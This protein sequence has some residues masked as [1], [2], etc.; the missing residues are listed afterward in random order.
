MN[1]EKGGGLG[2]GS[3]SKGLNKAKEAKGKVDEAKG[4]V[5]EAKGK[6]DEAKGDGKGK[7]GEGKEGDE[8]G[9]EGDGKGKEG[10][11]KGKEGEGKGK[12]G[13]G[14]EGEG[15]G[16]EGDNCDANNTR[17]I[18]ED[19][20]N[21][22]I[23]LKEQI[24]HPMDFAQN[25][26][27]EKSKSIGRTVKS[28]FVNPLECGKTVVQSLTDIIPNGIDKASLALDRLSKSMSKFSGSMEDFF[29]GLGGLEVPGYPHVLGPFEV[30]YAKVMVDLQGMLNKML[31][32]ENAAEILSDPK[33]DPKKLLDELMNMSKKYV[34]IS[35]SDE[36]KGIFKE[37]LTDYVEVVMNG[38]NLAKEPIERVKNEVTNIIDGL[39]NDLG[40]SVQEALTNVITLGLAAVPGVGTVIDIAYAAERVGKKII[41]SCE[42]PISKGAGI[43][44]P[45]ANKIN[46]GINDTKCRLN[47]LSKKLEPL[48]KT[49]Q[50]GGGMSI[51][52][53]RKNIQRTTKRVKRMLSRFTRK[54][55]L[56]TNYSKYINKAR[57]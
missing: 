4:K 18:A 5:D 32:G 30:M 15:D 2:L 35:K 13:E 27:K 9:K 43:V 29:Y 6:V 24:K 49:S 38:L 20:A 17:C 57:Y 50:A 39:G 33:Y 55:D 52:K 10:E 44:L 31:L 7:E 45:Y 34:D 40:K 41:E 56:K 16:K 53:K 23:G 47:Q 28:A 8:K 36:F 19:T 42:P 21:K 26:V 37:W 25:Y 51:E 1:N 11:E 3:I 22:L 12:E 46:K 54:R 14:K 48:M